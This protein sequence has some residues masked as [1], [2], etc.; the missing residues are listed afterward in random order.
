M[1]SS[2]QRSQKDASPKE[3]APGVPSF[4]SIITWPFFGRGLLYRLLIAEII[5]FLLLFAGGVILTGHMAHSLRNNIKQERLLLGKAIADDLDASLGN[6]AVELQQVAVQYESAGDIRQVQGSLD[7]L[8]DISSVFG[9]GVAVADK[10]GRVLIADRRHPGLAEIDLSQY[11]P[12][13]WDQTGQTNNVTAAAF[14]IIGTAIPWVAISVPVGGQHDG[15][16]VVGILDT[17]SSY[18]AQ[19]VNR[20]VGLGG[21]GHA[22]IVD[23]RGIDLF[24]TEPEHLLVGADHPTLYKRLFAQNNAT[25]TEFPQEEKGA[26]LPGTH[27]MAFVP[28]KSL[29]WAVSIGTTTSQA[30]SPVGRLWYYSLGILAVLSGL[31]F[32]ATTFIGR[33]LVQLSN[34][35]MVMTRELAEAQ[36]ELVSRNQYLSALNSISATVNQSLNLEDV[37][38]EATKKVL[39]VT[40]TEAGCV[41]LNDRDDG[42]LR[43]ASQVGSSSLFD[44]P[45]TAS[46][47]TSCVCYRVLRVGHPLVVNDPLQ[48]PLIG[49]RA[50]GQNTHF[51]AVPLKA[52][53]KALGVMNVVCSNHNCFTE[54]DF[55]LLESIGRHVGLAVENSI[56]YRDARQKE[57][58]RGQ[59]LN[60]VI[61]AQEDERKRVSRDFHDGFG[62]TLTGLIMSIESAEVA[63]S[64]DGPTIKDKLAKAR[65]VAVRAMEDM[66]KLLQNLRSPV[67]DEAGLAA[68]VRSYAASNLEAA[69]IGF[70]FEVAFLNGSLSPAAETAV[71]RIVQEAVHNIIKH[72]GARA[73]RIQLK[74]ETGKIIVVVE[75]DG[76]GFDVAAFMGKGG[77]TQSLG[78]ISMRERATALGGTFNINSRKG[79]GTQVIIEVPKDNGGDK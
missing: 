74:V 22:D 76:Q 51:V 49:N 39:E 2:D 35:S 55:K 46:P 14:R 48:C 1:Q 17:A 30:F 40:E 6:A 27:L 70:T 52:K 54:E 63:A 9:Q 12:S 60:A 20:A 33:R 4:K 26:P 10:A 11:A 38:M 41:L 18:P 24:S 23:A 13:L 8:A 53:D 31:A 42:R 62:Q 69:R 65:T 73:A 3:R 44:C 37:L 67:L 47:V 15:E 58:V 50:W 28:L 5:V 77:S 68:A 79:Q 16:R 25:V 7:M 56:L 72:S 34:T 32:L 78:L 43:L 45:H 75:D 66:R 71:F 36:D 57:E 61:T 19:V 64:T 21:S 59:L 29:P